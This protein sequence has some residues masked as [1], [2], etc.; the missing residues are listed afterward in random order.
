MVRPPRRNDYLLLG[1][2][3][4]ATPAELLRAYRRRARDLHPDVRPDDPEASRRFQ[5]L[6]A[7]YEALA[8][9][10]ARLAAAQP[11]PVV[12]RSRPGPHRGPPLRATPVVVRPFPD[13]E[14][15]R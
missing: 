4:R 1:V 13:A 7:A 9:Q 6:S 8:R 14:A 15:G 2:S 10:A 3:P 11:V 12:V 5:E